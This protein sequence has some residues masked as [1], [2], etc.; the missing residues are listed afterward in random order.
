MDGDCEN[1]ADDSFDDDATYART[2]ARCCQPGVPLVRLS[3]CR[4]VVCEGCLRANFDSVDGSLTAG[5]GVSRAP[6]VSAIR[7][8]CTA[9][10]TQH[11]GGS[12]WLDQHAAKPRPA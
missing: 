9:K 2:C 10:S 7:C 11:R 8:E 1:D 4:N 6:S 5:C 3:C 12:D